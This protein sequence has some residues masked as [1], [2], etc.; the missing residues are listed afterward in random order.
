MPITEQKAIVVISSH[1]RAHILN[2]NFSQWNKNH[3][4]RL[5]AV[6]RLGTV[7]LAND[8]WNSISQSHS[9]ENAEIW[10]SKMFSNLRETQDRKTAET[11]MPMVNGFTVL[12]QSTFGWTGIMQKL[13]LYKANVIRTWLKRIIQRNARPVQESMKTQSTWVSTFES[14]LEWTRNDTWSET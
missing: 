13:S 3:G 2:I 4:E 6:Y 8:F 9:W 12:H 5:R 14:L 11:Y 10:S 7:R 1:L